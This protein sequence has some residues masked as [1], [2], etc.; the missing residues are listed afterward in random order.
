MPG[1]KCKQHLKEI[2]FVIEPFV[3][4]W[5]VEFRPVWNTTFIVVIFKSKTTFTTEN[6]SFANF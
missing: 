3:L 6:L 4:T 1:E 2:F 5:F